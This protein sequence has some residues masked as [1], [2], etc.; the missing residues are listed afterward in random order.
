MDKNG[1]L[2][3]SSY[4]NYE[5]CKDFYVILYLLI[6]ER[7]YVK[8]EFKK[9]IL[10]VGVLLL[11]G[12]TVNATIKNGDLLGQ[13]DAAIKE[14]PVYTKQLQVKFGLLRNDLKIAHSF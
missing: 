13:L 7:R 6:N 1:T 14:R 9:S 2:V 11:I 12:V 3:Q 5:C 10:T 4:L 8:M